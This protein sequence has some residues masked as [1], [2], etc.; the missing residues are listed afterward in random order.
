[1]V[2]V[3]SSVVTRTAFFSTVDHDY[4]C[5]K[6]VVLLYS[7]VESSYQYSEEALYC[8]SIKVTRRVKRREH[9]ISAGRAKER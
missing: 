5:V 1:M 9:L 6:I 3:D 2:G 4:F 8:M 7:T